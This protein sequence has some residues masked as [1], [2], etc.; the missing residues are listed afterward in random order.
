MSEEQSAVEIPQIEHKSVA[1]NH[2]MYVQKIKR[3][4]QKSKTAQLLVI[5]K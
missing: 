3:K 2:L 1:R 4:K 5:L